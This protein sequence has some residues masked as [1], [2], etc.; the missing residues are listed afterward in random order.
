MLDNIRIVLVETTHPGNIGAAARAMK[1]MGLT[2][3]CLVMPHRYPSHEATARAAGADDVL[4]DARI[5]DSLDQALEGCSL[6]FGASARSRSI[7]WPQLDPRQAAART[8]RAA[9][10]GEVA[11]VFGREHAGLTN[12]ELD[13]CNYLVS[14]PANP[15]FASLNVA[16][17]V[18]ILSYELR[19][20]AL[21]GT[22]ATGA[23]EPLASAEERERF[24]RHLEQV[25][26]DLEFLNPDNP[27][28]LMRRLRRL[29]NRVE[30]DCNEVNILRGIL[31]AVERRGAAGNNGRSHT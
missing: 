26:L 3:L 12:L 6:V 7:P 1:N 14:I 13:R 21:E 17:A 23:E 8:M 31:T 24:Y 28:H 29:F 30:L 19:L 11:L 18:Q 15:E 16:A 9:V 25:L 20:A 5:C 10:A 22:P 2:R 27:K 4:A